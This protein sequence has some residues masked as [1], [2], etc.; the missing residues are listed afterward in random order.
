M[1]AAAAVF[2]ARLGAALRALPSELADGRVQYAVRA[3]DDEMDALARGLD[4]GS[5]GLGLMLQLRARLYDGA[6]RSAARR[7][8]TRLVAI[9]CGFDDRRLRQVARRH[10]DV[11]EVEHRAV[12]AAAATPRPTAPPMTR[13]AVDDLARDAWRALQQRGADAGRSFFLLQGCG[14][15]GDA[16][17]LGEWLDRLR[18]AAVTGS[19]LLLDLPDAAT[20]DLARHATSASR[21]DDGA[22]MVPRFGLARACL[23]HAIADRG[24]R[25]LRLFDST[26]LQRAYLGVEDLAVREL[27]AWVGTPA[28]ATPAGT[29]S[30][31]ATTVRRL[32]AVQ[33]ATRSSRPCLRTALRASSVGDAQAVAIRAVTA[34]R[35]CQVTLDARRAAAARLMDGTRTIDALT[36]A[37]GARDVAETIELLRRHDVLAHPAAADEAYAIGMAASAAGEP[38]RATAAFEEALSRDPGHLGAL[39]ETAYAAIESGDRAAARRARRRLAPF[40][41]NCAVDHLRHALRRCRQGSPLRLD[42]REHV[43]VL[44]APSSTAAD[45]RTVLAAAHQLLDQMTTVLAVELVDHVLIDVSTARIGIPVTM[46]ADAA[47][48]TLVSI[49]QPTYSPSALCHE[50]TH[51]LAMSA[52]AWLSEGVAVWMQRRIAPGRC[53]PDDR[54]CTEQPTHRRTLEAL[55]GTAGV[56]GSASRCLARADYLQAA[57][58]VAVAVETF[59]LARFR[60][61]FTALRTT[62][63]SHALAEACAA[64]DVPSWSA[65]DDAWV[66]S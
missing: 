44:S 16:L 37:A 7:G 24:L 2:R 28:T 8:F 54:Q 63:D 64:L 40:V 17:A 45:A 18:D 59:G 31:P 36:A 22:S 62:L 20:L 34:M 50:L 35:V 14:L 61:F 57:D 38:L 9:G 32:R 56:N 27:Y 33:R 46:I 21:G 41:G 3:R 48:S 52:S 19:E 4:R 65:L 51:V 15:W 49:P 23:R 47:P 5:P 60:R 55:L 42:R 29:S 39:R 6:F 25:I 10:G 43:A 12:L 26:D 66:T 30:A 53:F 1:S 11:I 58:F 13:I